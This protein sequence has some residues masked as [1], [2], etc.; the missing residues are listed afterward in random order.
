MRRRASPAQP[1]GTVGKE[2]V[3]MSLGVFCFLLFTAFTSIQ[4][5]TPNIAGVWVL[6]PALTVKPDE[7][8]FVTDWANTAG[9]R[10]ESGGRSGGRGRR[11]GGSS[12]GGMNA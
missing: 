3:N 7:V 9:S 12:G 1:C 11:G 5:N 4:S 6:N 10:G 8:G 2:F